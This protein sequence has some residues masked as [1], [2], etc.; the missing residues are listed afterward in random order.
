MKSL[1]WRSV[2][3]RNAWDRVVESLATAEGVLGSSAE[4]LSHT[5]RGLLA[6]NI[7]DV[8]LTELDRLVKRRQQELAYRRVE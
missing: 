8:K 6:E 4:Y 2:C 5:V 3:F 1:A 7:A